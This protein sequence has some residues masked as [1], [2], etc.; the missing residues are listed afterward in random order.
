MA[1]LKESFKRLLHFDKKSSKDTLLF[2]FFVAMA[3]AFWI[4]LSFNNNMTHDLVVKVK[5][6]KPANVTLLQEVPSSQG[7]RTSIPQTVLSFRSFY[8]S[9]I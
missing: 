9:K 2:L 1:W 8:Q 3:A 7:P 6:T 4:L 5:V